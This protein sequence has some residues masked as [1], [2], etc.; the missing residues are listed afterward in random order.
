MKWGARKTG[1]ESM[2]GCA[3]PGV[4]ELSSR[5][6]L[7]AGRYHILPVCVGWRCAMHAGLHGC[8]PAALLYF[9]GIGSGWQPI[10]LFFIWVFM[11]LLLRWLEA[12]AAGIFWPGA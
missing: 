4:A 6:A 7:P 8:Q 2:Q 1:V 11:I 9:Q 5:L 12:Q 3:R 10:D